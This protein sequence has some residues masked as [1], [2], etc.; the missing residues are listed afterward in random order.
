MMLHYAAAGLLALIAIHYAMSGDLTRFFLRHARVDSAGELQQ[1]NPNA[2]LGF[3]IVAVLWG[4]A[5]SLL[6]VPSVPVA[7]EAG[8]GMVAVLAAI[9]ALLHKPRLIVRPLLLL[10]SGTLILAGNLI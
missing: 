1:H 7:I 9:A 4:G 6:I 2:I 10:A 3:I 8:L 5:L